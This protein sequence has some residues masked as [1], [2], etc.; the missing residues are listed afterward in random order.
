MEDTAYYPCI[1]CGNKYQSKKMYL[2]HIRNT[3]ACKL[4]DRKDCCFCGSIFVSTKY[5]RNHIIHHCKKKSTTPKLIKPINDNVIPDPIN[6]NKVNKKS[7]N[8]QHITNDVV[9]NTDSDCD[10]IFNRSD[11]KEELIDKDYLETKNN[12]ES[13]SKFLDIIKNLQ[14]DIKIKNETIEKLEDNIDKLYD[15]IEGLRDT[16]K[17]NNKID[18]LVKTAQHFNVMNNKDVDI[19]IQ[20]NIIDINEKKD[21]IIPVDLGVY[22]FTEEKFNLDI[23]EV[24]RIFGAGTN[25]PLIITKL[26]NLNPRK[27]SLNNIYM[28]SI[29]DTSI[30][31]F[32]EG[33]W[34]MEDRDDILD[35]L[36]YLQAMRVYH[37]YSD[38][39]YK[40]FRSDKIKKAL[41]ILILCPNMDELYDK[42][43]NRFCSR[44]IPLLVDN[45][46]ICNTQKGINGPRGIYLLSN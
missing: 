2:E 20:N 10:D 46:K 7:G 37:Y 43:Y 5:L 24:E 11:K 13:I 15:I 18:Q 41:D 21:I 16:I 14:D 32:R 9:D 33:L 34:K 30:N 36:F 26:T 8:K 27:K 23:D 38:E 31:V 35:K 29:D 4:K 44:I 12:E 45:K 42:Y 17:Q 1:I 39:Q 19:K 6:C 25:S 40:D 22:S 28:D 3:Y